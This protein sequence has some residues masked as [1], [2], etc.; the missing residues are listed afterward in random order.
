MAVAATVVKKP[1]PA[2]MAL[3]VGGECPRVAQDARAGR[4]RQSAQKQRIEPEQ[5]LREHGDAVQVR[6]D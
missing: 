3:D 6:G 1:T 4:R 2:A 5:D